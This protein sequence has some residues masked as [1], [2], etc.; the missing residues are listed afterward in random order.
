MVTE[1]EHLD[2]VMDFEW[3]MEA[4]SDSDKRLL[5]L[6]FAGYTQ[7]YIGGLFGGM[8]QR[9]VSYNLRRIRELLRKKMTT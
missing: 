8:S 7:E 5:L 4:L 9:M 1:W 2:M 6:Y 3:A